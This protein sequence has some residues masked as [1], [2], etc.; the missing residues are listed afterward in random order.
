MGP[1]F[2]RSRKEREKDMKAL[3]MTDLEGITGVDSIDMIFDQGGGY[4]TA[5]ENLMADVNAAADGLF[6]AGLDEVFV[7]DGHGGGANFIPSLLDPRVTWL[8]T[9]WEDVIRERK[10]DFYGEVGLHAMAGTP[11]AF[12]DHTQNSREWF[13]YEINGRPSGELAQG[14]GFAGVF[15]IP[16]LLVT[17]DFAVCEE[18]KY[19]LGDIAVAAVKRAVGRNRAVSLPAGEARALIREAAVRAAGLV[20]TVRPYRIHMPAELTFVFQRTDYCEN[21]QNDKN[22]RVGPRTLKKRLD[23]IESYLDLMP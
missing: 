11:N 18:A 21:H 5:C 14:A 6:A 12:L 23:R 10:V 13:S 3:L 15:G 16:T 7:V 9:G 1:A 22:E 4:K 8:K 20:G 2:R 19:L 17:G